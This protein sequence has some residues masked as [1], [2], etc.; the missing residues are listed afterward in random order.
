MLD[1]WNEVCL[2]SSRSLALEGIFTTE[3]N[4]IGVMKMPFKCS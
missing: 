4:E 1:V 2:R 3:V